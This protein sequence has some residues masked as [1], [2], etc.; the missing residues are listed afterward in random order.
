MT[1]RLLKDIKSVSY[2]LPLSQTF[3]APKF[4]LDLQNS[5]YFPESKIKSLGK[6]IAAY[7]HVKR[8]HAHQLLNKETVL[9]FKRGVYYFVAWE[10]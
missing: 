6:F 9:N 4:V 3:Y 1:Q 2:T 5:Y 7:P 8:E 10:D